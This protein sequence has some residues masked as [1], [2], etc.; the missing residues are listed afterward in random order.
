LAARS[1]KNLSVSCGDNAGEGWYYDYVM[2]PSRMLLCP[3]TCRR[4][5]PDRAE[6]RLG[7]HP[8]QG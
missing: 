6:I 1:S 2:Q 8:R 4:F 5:V 3:E 7:C